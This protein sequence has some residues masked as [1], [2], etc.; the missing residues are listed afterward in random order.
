MPDP[1]AGVFLE[2]RLDEIGLGLYPWDNCGRR[3]KLIDVDDRVLFGGFIESIA[4]DFDTVDVDEG[5]VVITPRG[6]GWIIEASINDDA[7]SEVGRKH[8]WRFCRVTRPVV[9]RTRLNMSVT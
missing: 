3:F 9:S 6:G 1:A 4:I 8:P 7:D 5:D 2:R